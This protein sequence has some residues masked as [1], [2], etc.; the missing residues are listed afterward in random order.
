MVLRLNQQPIIENLR[1][2]S[3]ETID[4]LRQMLASGVQ[5]Q[6]DPRRANFYELENCSQIYY[7]HISPLNGKVI[8]LGIWSKT[9]EPVAA[10]AV[11]SPGAT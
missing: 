4:K 2:Y 3:P 6:P 5:G 7:V 8:L 11:G 10:A 9:E 1:N